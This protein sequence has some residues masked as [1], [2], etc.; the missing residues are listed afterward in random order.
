MQIPAACVRDKADLQ[1]QQS[2]DEA[3]QA[4]GQ[5]GQQS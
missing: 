3:S 1:R 5:T 4:A 2:W